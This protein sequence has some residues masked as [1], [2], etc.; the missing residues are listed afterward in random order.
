MAD[1]D[2]MEQKPVTMLELKD[3]LSNIK[4]SG[5][6]LNFRADKVHTYLDEFLAGSKK[7]SQDL[8]KKLS[9]LKIQKLKE[10]YIVKIIDT[11]PEDQDALKTIFVGETSTFKQEE[12]KQILDAIHG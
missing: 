10:R 5:K 7:T 2:V 6:E 3:K 4:K 8:Y 1:I 11:M 9:E 12:L